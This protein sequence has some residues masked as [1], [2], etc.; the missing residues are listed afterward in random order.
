[1]STP[2]PEIYEPHDSFSSTFL[3]SLSS[4]TKP[5]KLYPDRGLELEAWVSGGKGGEIGEDDLGGEES[6]WGGFYHIAWNYPIILIFQPLCGV[7]A[8][9]C[10]VLIKPSEVV[11]TVSKLL[12]EIVPKYLDPA[13]YGVALGGIPEI[14]QILKLKWSHIFSTGNARVARI[15]PAAAAKHLT[16]MTFGLGGK[17]PVIIDGVNL[18]EE[19][20]V[21]AA[22]RVVWRKVIAGPRCVRFVLLRCVLVSILSWI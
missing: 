1:M 2:L 10:P 17:I 8:A 7:I 21:V 19:E 22:W 5:T 15:I 12:S 20:L 16:L 6:E 9:G 14:T 18:G 3:T 4:H 11:P 13:A